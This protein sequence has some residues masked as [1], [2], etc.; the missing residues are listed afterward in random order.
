MGL[1]DDDPAKARQRWRMEDEGG[2]G[3]VKG[4]VN[5]PEHH[6][7]SGAKCGREKEERA[8]FGLFLGIS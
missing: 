3:L 1:E 2:D 5:W 8:S 7:E 6:Q 4:V